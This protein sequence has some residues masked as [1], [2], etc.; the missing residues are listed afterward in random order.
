MTDMTEIESLEFDLKIAEHN[1]WVAQTVVEDKE[2]EVDKIKS[3]I[4]GIKKIMK[5][6]EE[7]RNDKD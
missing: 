2:Y 3:Q 4:N 7:I 5:R 6:L 1:L